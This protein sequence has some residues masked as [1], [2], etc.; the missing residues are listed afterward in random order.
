MYDHPILF[1]A[2]V[3]AVIAAMLVVFVGGINGYNDRVCRDYGAWHHAALTTRGLI[4][5]R[6][7]GTN[8]LF[9]Y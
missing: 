8:D 7:L 3:G 5:C 4:A 1:F 9:F 2:A 6:Q